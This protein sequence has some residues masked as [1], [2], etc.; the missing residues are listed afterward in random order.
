[1]VDSGALLKR[2]TFNRVPGVRIPPSPPLYP[3]LHPRN[4]FFMPLSALEIVHEAYAAFG[5]RDVPKIVS[6][7]SREIALVQSE[8]LP[9]GGCFRGHDGALQFFGKLTSHITSAVEVDRTIQSGDHIAVTGWTQ[10]TVNATGTTFRVPLV[11]VWHVRD[12]LVNRIQFFIDNPTM[13]A[14][15]SSTGSKH[16][17]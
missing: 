11:H 9:W 10:G 16:I 13:L 15:L 17:V 14:A 4:G 6:L 7:F 12:G 2:C 1:V 3:F 5:R 8:E